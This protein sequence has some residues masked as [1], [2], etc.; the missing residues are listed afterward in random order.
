MEQT[1]VVKF[2]INAIF[3]FAEIYIY[4]TKNDDFI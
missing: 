4:Q 3:D 2:N 1:A